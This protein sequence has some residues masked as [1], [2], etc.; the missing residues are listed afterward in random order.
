LAQ[1]L[2][3]LRAGIVHRDL[4][5][6]NILMGRGMVANEVYL[7]DHGSAEKY[8]DMMT[9]KHRLADEKSGEKT[10]RSPAAA[11]NPRPLWMASSTLP[12]PVMGDR[13]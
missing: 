6:E 13:A 12:V 7:I 5:P 4:C 2:F 1:Q 3:A 10:S 9:G 8:T 11:R